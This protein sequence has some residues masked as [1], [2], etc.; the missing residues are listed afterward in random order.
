MGYTPREQARALTFS[1]LQAVRSWAAAERARAYSSA[2]LYDHA[3]KAAPAVGAERAR[4]GSSSI[5]CCWR[6]ACVDCQSVCA[7]YLPLCSCPCHT[8]AC[9][10]PRP[11]RALSPTPHALRIPELAARLC[12]P[13]LRRLLSTTVLS[14]LRAMWPPWQNWE[15]AQYTLYSSVTI[16]SDASRLYLDAR[17]C[18]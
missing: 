4:T 6:T 1:L 7:S 12:Q 16:T 15:R 8:F 5:V 11:T 17:P 18:G 2:E 14:G 13:M 10:L 9:R 3:G